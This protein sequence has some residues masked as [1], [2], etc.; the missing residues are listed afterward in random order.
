M[1]R[2]YLFPLVVLWWLLLAFTFVR[3]LIVGLLSHWTM[4][5]LTKRKELASVLAGSFVEG[6]V[7]DGMVAK[8]HIKTSS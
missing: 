4:A 8:N 7:L 1:M 3:G 2:T 6:N 5:E